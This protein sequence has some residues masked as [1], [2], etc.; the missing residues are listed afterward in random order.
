M[1]EFDVVCLGVVMP[2]RKRVVF[3]RT[4][5]EADQPLFHIPKEDDRGKRLGHRSKA[6]GGIGCGLDFV[7]DV[8]VA[9]CLL[10]DDLL[11]F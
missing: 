3:A 2:I 10:P 11:V 7:L 6:V 1:F 5:L 4:I 9:P 8:R